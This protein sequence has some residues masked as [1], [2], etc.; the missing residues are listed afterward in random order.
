MMNF[1]TMKRRR[2]AGSHNLEAFFA[3]YSRRL[4]EPLDE[5]LSPVLA[6]DETMPDLALVLELFGRYLASHRH[7]LEHARARHGQA[8]VELRLARRAR[9][10][11]RQ[12][13]RSVFTDHPGAGL[14]GRTRRS[15]RTTAP[16]GKEGIWNSHVQ[17]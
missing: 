13:L 10:E 12:G 3:A 17:T 11:A 6:P 16:G 5:K 14:P 8:T 1:S 7:A 9:D 4:G 2:L 15:G